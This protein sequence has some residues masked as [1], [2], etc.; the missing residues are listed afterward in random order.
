MIIISDDDILHCSLEKCFIL[1]N[2]KS[3]NE[4]TAW[5]TTS[6]NTCLINHRKRLW[7]KLSTISSAVAF[8]GQHLDW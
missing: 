5:A 6:M 1:Q 2:R 8:M 7:P 3:D 4:K